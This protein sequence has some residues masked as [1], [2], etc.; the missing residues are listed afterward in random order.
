MWQ[1]RGCTLVTDNDDGSGNVL[2][3]A[4]LSDGRQKLTFKM[5]TFD[6]R[7]N[8]SKK[9][10]RKGC[11]RQRDDRRQEAVP[12]PQRRHDGTI[13]YGPEMVPEG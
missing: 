8:L 2:A 3:V 10:T 9:M 13:V 4:I 11:R 12:D 1:M 6:R 7:L 5:A